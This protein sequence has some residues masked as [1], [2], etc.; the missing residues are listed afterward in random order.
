MNKS[1]RQHWLSPPADSALA[2]A[3][4]FGI[5]PSITFYNMYVLTPRERLELADKRISEAQRM[6]LAREKK[7]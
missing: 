4:A 6:R 7:P 2:R 5:D 3:T 1:L